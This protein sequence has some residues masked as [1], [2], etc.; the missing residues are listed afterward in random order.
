MYY[1]YIKRSDNPKSIAKFTDVKPAFFEKCLIFL[2]KFIPIE[3]IFL[4][5][6]FLSLYNL[7]KVL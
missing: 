3:I 6:M 2:T 5:L 1:E 4:L 7:L